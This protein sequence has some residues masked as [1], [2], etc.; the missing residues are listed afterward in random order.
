MKKS[1]I[2]FC[3]LVFHINIFADTFSNLELSQIRR[4]IQQRLEQIIKTQDENASAD[5][6]FSFKKPKKKNKI[7]NPF[8]LSTI[9]PKEV[10]GKEIRSIRISIFSRFTKKTIPKDLEKKLR[11]ITREYAKSYSFTY[12]EKLVS[13]ASFTD[14][15]KELNLFEAAILCSLLGVILIISIGAGVMFFRRKSRKSDNLGD[16]I[17]DSVSSLKSAIETLAASQGMRDEFPQ[18]SKPMSFEINTGSDSFMKDLNIESLEEIFMDCYW[19][20]EDEYASFLWT[21]LDISRKSKILSRNKLMGDYANYISNLEGI[22]TGNINETYYFNPLGLGSIDNEGLTK[23]IKKYKSVFHLLPKVRV[24]NLKIDASEKRV[25]MLTK[26][27]KQ[28]TELE[29]QNI[30]W[31]EYKTTRSRSFDS[32]HVFYF[33]S[34]EEEEKFFD[35]GKVDFTLVKSFPSLV[36]LTYLREDDILDILD[37]FTAKELAIAWEGPENVLIKLESVLP[38]KKVE[39]LKS[40]QSQVESKRESPIFME[41]VRK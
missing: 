37:P 36:W 41:I 6:I 1:F 25:L 39:L 28:D 16:V 31:D 8:I 11:A 15:L 12:N 33:E 19:C 9:D 5:V 27:S 40:Y 21:K 14:Q 7:E 17:T 13:K 30:N 10:E 20:E 26:F 38:E 3:F 4:D 35:E 18:T 32:S 24:A 23:L 29:L 34:L 2:I 22:D